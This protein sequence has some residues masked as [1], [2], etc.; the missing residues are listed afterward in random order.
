M[1]G[2][3]RIRRQQDAVFPFLGDGDDELALF[4]FR[5]DVAVQRIAF[6]L[7]DPAVHLFAQHAADVPAGILVVGRRLDVQEVVLVIRKVAFAGPFRG[8]GSALP[9]LA[10]GGQGE[11]QQNA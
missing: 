6:L 3:A 1:I 11:K 5:H 7:D 10:A 2:L 9:L 4:I 8:S